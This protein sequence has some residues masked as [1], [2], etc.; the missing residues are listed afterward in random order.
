[1]QIKVL[2]FG[3]L[4]D[5]V[6]KQEILLTDVADSTDLKQHLIRNYPAMKDQ[7]FAIAVNHEIINEEINLKEDDEVAIIPPFQGG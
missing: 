6:G 2:F 5:V 1:M 4:I 7:K 3:S